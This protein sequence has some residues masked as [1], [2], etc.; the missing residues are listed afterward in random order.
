MCGNSKFSPQWDFVARD[1]AWSKFIC[2]TS[3]VWRKRERSDRV[4]KLFKNVNMFF[5]LNY[6]ENIFYN[7]LIEFGKPA[8]LVRIVK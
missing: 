1:T 6:E 2:I 8:K 5:C 7:I 4:C 3:N